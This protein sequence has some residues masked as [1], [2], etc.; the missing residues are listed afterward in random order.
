MS[1]ICEAQASSIDMLMYYDTRPSCFNGIFDFYT[2]KPL[3]GYYSMYWYGMFYDMK[4]W[5]P[6]ENKLD[7]IYTLCGIDENGKTMAIV[8][9]YSDDDNAPNKS[10]KLDFGRCGNYEIYALDSEKDGELVGTTS[11]LTFDLCIHSSVLIK[12]I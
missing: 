5:I 10:V 8:T 2:Y 9:Y 4:A 7:N 6:A 11:D 3:K 12:E 1:C